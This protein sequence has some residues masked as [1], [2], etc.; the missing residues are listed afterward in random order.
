MRVLLTMSYNNIM[1][2]IIP[3]PR[4]LGRLS[5][6]LLKNQIREFNSHRVHILVGTFSCI[7]NWLAE[8]TSAWVSNIRWRSTSSGNAEPYERQKL[9]ART[10]G[11]KGRHLWPRFVQGIVEGKTS[12]ELSWKV[13]VIIKTVHIALLPNTFQPHTFLTSL[14]RNTKSQLCGRS[15]IGAEM[16]FLLPTSSILIMRW[17]TQKVKM[18]G[19]RRCGVQ[20]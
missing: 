15:A 16:P 3:T 4:W 1:L 8:S 19:N 5:S 9:K 17:T 13:K 14:A 10:G 2:D 20:M 7:N 11:E 18:K 12:N 6:C